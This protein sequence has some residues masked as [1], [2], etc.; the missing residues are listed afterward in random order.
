M[1]KVLNPGFYTTIQDLGRFGYRNHGVPISGCMDAISA[2]LANALLNNMNTDAVLEIALAGPKL[3]FSTKTII[4]ITGAD[5][6]PKINNKIIS[7]NEPIEIFEGDVLSFGELKNGA[8][9]YLAVKNGFDSELILNSRSQFSNISIRDRLKKNDNLKICGNSNKL[10][11]N[12]IFNKNKKPFFNTDSIEITSGPEFDLFSKE[13]IDK[14]LNQKFTISKDNNRMGYQMEE[15]TIKHN[16]S[17]ITSPVI[18]G[19]VQLLPS[20]KI[21]ILMKDA[22]TTGGYPRIFQLTDFSIAVLAQKQAMDKINLKLVK[23]S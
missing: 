5:M 19:T 7:K 2:N 14:V 6:S 1:I 3:L 4:A 20:G 21:I 9:S 8:R 16:N 12:N 15:V 18:P 22:Q 10:K 13:E 23:L 11:P 17:M